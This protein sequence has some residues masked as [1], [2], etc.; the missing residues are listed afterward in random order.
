MAIIGAVRGARAAL[1]GVAAV[2]ACG[3]GGGN[4]S[5][6]ATPTP[7]LNGEQGKTPS[8]VLDDAHTALAAVSSVSIDASYTSS[9]GTITFRADVDLANKRAHLIGSEGAGKFE[10]IVTDSK[11]YLLGDKAFYAATGQAAL[12]DLVDG[13]WV[14]PPAGG[15]VTGLL[16]LVD[17]SNFADCVLGQTHGTLTIGGTDTVSGTIVLN[18]VDAGDVDGSAPQTISVSLVGTAYPVQVRQTGAYKGGVAKAPSC[19]LASSSTTRGQATIHH[20]GV[21]VQVS[22][23]ANPIDLS[24]LGGGGPTPAPP[25]P[26]P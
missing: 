6:S 24:L 12:G 1:A 3:C 17:R 21:N 14:V 11:V 18:V 2:I 8:Q 15:L 5:S 26:T 25:A 20:V 10:V 9:A 23:P 16:A 22:A 7:S 13:Q 19:S 4:S